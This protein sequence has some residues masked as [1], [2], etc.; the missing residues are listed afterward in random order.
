LAVQWGYDPAK[1]IYVLPGSGGVKQ[2]LFYPAEQVQGQKAVDEL[3]VVNP[4][5]LRAYVRS[6]TFFKAIPIT[7]Q[8]DPHLRFV[9]TAMKAEP[10]AEHWVR[11]LDIGRWVSLLPRLLHAEMA[12]L[13]RQAQIV[14]SPSEHDG[15]PNTLLEAMACGCFPIAGDLESL[16]EW[17]VPGVNGLLFNPSDPEEMAQAILIAASQPDLRKAAREYNFGLIAKRAEYRQVMERAEN[18][19]REISASSPASG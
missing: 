17:I 11:E 2:D 18:Y 16:R 6:D 15:T 5:G 4:R 14:V 13:F 8:K 3:L 1:P 9:C 10:E 12:S 7:I 19:Y